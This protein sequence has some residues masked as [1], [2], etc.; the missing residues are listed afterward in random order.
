[1]RAT[2]VF[3]FIISLT[4]LSAVNQRWEAYIEFEIDS[5]KELDQLSRLIS[6]DRVEGRKVIANVNRTELSKLSQLGYS[7]RFLPPLIPP[8]IMMAITPAQFREWN[9]YPTYDTYIEVMYQYAEDYTDICKIENIGM[10]VEGR[11]LLFVKISDNVEEE[12][13]EPEFM[14][15]AQMHG[16]ELVTYILMLDLIEHLLTNYGSNPQITNL[17]D[18]IEIWINPLANPDGT[19]AGGNDTVSG[20]QRRNA[21]N[22]DLNR[23]FPDMLDGDHPDG[24]E[25]QP[26][27]IAMMDFFD[28]HH[29]VLSSNLH[30]GSEVVNYPWDRIQQR[31]ADDDWW[32][33]VSRTYADAVHEIAPPGYM[34]GFDNGITN[35]WDWYMITGGRQDYLNYFKNCR[36][37]TLE[38]SNTKFLPVNQLEDHWSWNREALLLYI[39]E[40]LYGI[41]GVT[42]ST[43]GNPL[44][45]KIEI[46]DH[47]N[48]N[49]YIYSDPT[50]GNYHRMLY[51]GN[52][53]LEV[54][55]YGYYTQIIDNISVNDNE[56]TYLDIVLEE[57][58]YFSISGYVTNINTGEG[59]CGAAIEIL[60]IPL[61]PVF[62]DSTGFYQFESVAAGNYQI[63]VSALH[64]LPHQELIGINEENTEFDFSLLRGFTEDFEYAEI[65]FYFST[66]G[67]QNWISDN[68]FVYEGDFSIR[69]GDIGNNQ[70]STLSV[71]L[72]FLEN[73]MISFYKKVSCEEDDNNNYD[74]L[75]FSIDGQEQERWDGENNWS[76]EIFDL[77]TGEH[78]LEWEYH[79]DG[80]VSEGEDAAWLDYI[81]FPPAAE[82]ETALSAEPDSLYTEVTPGNNLYESITLSNEGFGDCNY[83]LMISEDWLEYGPVSGIIEQSNQ[84]FIAIEI[85]CAPII[86]GEYNADII[87]DYNSYFNSGQI[88][89]PW[90]VVVTESANGEDQI[91]Y[92]TT[93]NHNFPNP[94]NPET[95]ISYQISDASNVK[96]TIYNIKGQLI[97]NLVDKLHSRG[98]YSV[99]W[100]G[101]DNYLKPV[102]SGIYFY[103]MQATDYDS[104][105]K[106]IMIK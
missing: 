66:S 41:R 32:Q 40:C 98:K 23:N 84:L 1:M 88:V 11:E 24:N 55:C 82:F 27:N 62:S 16:D 33:E 7:Y 38:L 15:S 45:S 21:N 42:S 26:E 106:M 59:I 20:A 22:V 77:S 2:I 17:V 43:G 97:K 13:N 57:A 81:T 65:P 44:V 71:T 74:Y 28:A 64:H 100:D 80:S 49:S 12:E 87:I 29:F 5:R 86:P 52:Y 37:M 10:S 48:N 94:F 69:S 56:V 4:I 19:Y 89:I 103:R 6:I 36:E 63:R 93:L 51:P 31:H 25:W 18:E 73:R 34:D 78:T 91:P 54:S 102:P 72:D 105:K 8:D 58:P 39:K 101:R 30:S 79:K 99:V 92:I 83:S 75:K 35:G 67:N 46:P 47:D 60:D 85:P 14:Y 104:I 70:N 9:Y 50:F 95:A 53:D 76:E 96:L 3:T 68:Q 90:T 61:E